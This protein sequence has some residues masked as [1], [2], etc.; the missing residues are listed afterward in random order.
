MALTRDARWT[1]L[2]EE[3]SAQASDPRLKATIAAALS[4][5]HGGDLR[6]LEDPLRRVAQ[7]K[8]RRER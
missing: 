3:I 7:D 1:K 8:I 5:L 2:L 6:A 4:V